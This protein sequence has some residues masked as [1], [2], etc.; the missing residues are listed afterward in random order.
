MGHT[1]VDHPN[2]LYCQRKLELGRITLEI[3]ATR[4]TLNSGP[5]QLSPKRKLVLQEH[6]SH[7]QR[8]LASV[9][10]FSQSD[11]MLCLF[12]ALPVEITNQATPAWPKPTFLINGFICPLT[13]PISHA[14]PF[15]N[16]EELLT[17]Q[18]RRCFQ[19]DANQQPFPFDLPGTSGFMIVSFRD[20]GS[21]AS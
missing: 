16:P 5:I 7:N 14:H 15:R 19:V 4:E 13:H 3:S 18:Q 17:S 20:E 12:K 6:S 9:T 1:N 21:L 8:Y 10:W 11:K 2:K